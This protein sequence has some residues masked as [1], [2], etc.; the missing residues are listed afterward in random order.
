MFDRDD[1]VVFKQKRKKNWTDPVE[2]E[3]YLSLLDENCK[4]LSFL[5][6]NL[7]LYHKMS[8]KMANLGF[9]REPY[10]LRKKLSNIISKYK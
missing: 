7:R 3:A 2:M 5:K 9:R 8:Y 6:R 4:E 10:E 1:E